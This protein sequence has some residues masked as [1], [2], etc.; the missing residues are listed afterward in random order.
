[1][2]TYCLD[3]A[4]LDYVDS[5]KYLGVHVTSKL[6]WT[7]HIQYPCSKANRLLGIIQRSCHF[8]KNPLQKK[9]TVFSFIK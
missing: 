8:V 9:G 6:N 5:E 1:M 4:C 3:G 7:Q 2:Y